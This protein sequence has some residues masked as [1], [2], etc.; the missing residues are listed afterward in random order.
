MFRIESGGQQGE[1]SCPFTHRSSQTNRKRW[2]LPIYT[3]L[4]SQQE[5]N[6]LSSSPSNS[7]AKEKGS[8]SS[9]NEKLL[10]FSLSDYS[11]GLFV[12]N[13]PSNS[14]L[15][16]IKETSSPLFCRL[17]CDFARTC[18]SQMSILWYS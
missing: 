5:E 7:L 3:A 9:A 8:P 2:T 14:P 15:S 11:N 17:A 6:K 4:L 10:Y 12:Y 18:S 13:N 16:W 1:L